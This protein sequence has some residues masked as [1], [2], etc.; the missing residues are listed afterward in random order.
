MKLMSVSNY[1]K[2]ANWLASYRR[3]MKYEI[4]RTARSK[5]RYSRARFASSLVMPNR[6]RKKWAIL[7]LALPAECPPR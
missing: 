7:C 1:T 6:K 3:R 4:K 5:R 2:V